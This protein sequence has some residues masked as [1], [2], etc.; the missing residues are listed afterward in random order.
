MIKTTIRRRNK[1]ASTE[2]M[3][4]QLSLL[5]RKVHPDVFAAD[6]GVVDGLGDGL[7]DGAGAF[8]MSNMHF[9]RLV[10]VTLMN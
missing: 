9:A 5:L 1:R 2:T 3:P 6:G 8:S 4:T 10:C 7:G